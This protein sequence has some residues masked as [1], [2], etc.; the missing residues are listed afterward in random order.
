MPTQRASRYGQ[1]PSTTGYVSPRSPSPVPTRP[2]NVATAPAAQTKGERGSVTGQ[3][4]GHAARSSFDSAALKMLG[5][6]LG[7]PTV[8]SKEDAL[9]EADQL[10]NPTVR[11]PRSDVPQQVTHD[12]ADETNTHGAKTT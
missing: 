2:V 3:R 4:L 6:M 10:L 9:R 11:D 7:G 1:L 5:G 12:G 8:R